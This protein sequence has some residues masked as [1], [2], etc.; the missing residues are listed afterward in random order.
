MAIAASLAIPTASWAQTASGAAQQEFEALF[1]ELLRDPSN[2]ALNLRF[3]EIALEIGDYEAAIGA[4]D[5][6]LYSE[7]DNPVY[8]LQIADA[9]LALESYPAARGFYDS[10]LTLP[11]ASPEQRELA[12]S[13]IA[14]IEN[15]TR[16]SPWALYGQAGLRY[17]T[18]ASSGPDGLDGV[19][20]DAAAQSDWNA[21]VVGVLSYN[22]PVGDGAIE[23]SLT[24]YYADQ[25]EIDRLDLGVAELTA[26]PR[27][28]IASG[29][30]MSLSLRPFGLVTGVLL[31][32]DP[33]LGAYGGGVS[34]RARLADPLTLEPYFE[35]RNRTYFNSDDYPTATDQTGELFTYA[36]NGYGALGT[37]LSWSGRG[38][39]RDND[40][41]EAFEGYD[42]YFADL[43]L[44]ILLGDSD[45]GSGRRWVLTPSGSVEWTDY[46]APD[47][48]EMVTRSDFE[49]KAGARLD[50]PVTDTFGLGVQ[51]Q[52]LRNNSNRAEFDY[53]NLQVTSGPTVRF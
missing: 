20:P 27:L 12:T 31:G 37:N 13:K 21:F 45:G 44:R 18:N 51:V 22:Q 2:R 16:P 10:V 46:D 28:P 8:L 24:T 7:P 11:A 15:R 38:G 48:N 35:Y 26:G 17:Q 5:R 49:W 4:L 3:I 53:D 32:D 39:L 40:A 23:A 9:Y 30:N 41:R 29:E 42:E 34:A 25:F 33:Y 6:L 47:P 1:Q 36:I 14:Q 43:S 50:V 19:D 52:Y